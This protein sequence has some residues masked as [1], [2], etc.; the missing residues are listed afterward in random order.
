MAAC[1]RSQGGNNDSRN[2]KQKQLQ[3][4]VARWSALPRFFAAC[5]LSSDAVKNFGKPLT[6]AQVVIEGQF[7]TRRLGWI[8]VNVGRNKIKTKCAE[9][10]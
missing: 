6:S 1:T 5:L 3:N 9:S 4:I 8:L 10:P 7:Y 2:L